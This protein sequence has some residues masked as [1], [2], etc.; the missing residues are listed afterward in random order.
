[1]KP[2]VVPAESSPLADQ[3]CSDCGR[4]ELCRRGRRMFCPYLKGYGE[5]GGEP[6]RVW[7]LLAVVARPNSL[8]FEL[9]IRE[10]HQLPLCGES[11]R[12]IFLPK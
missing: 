9:S 2:A 4:C 6:A 11:Y 1:M 5:A 7:C 3:R 8:G 10:G 12:L